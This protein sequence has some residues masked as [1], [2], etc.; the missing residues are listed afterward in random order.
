MDKQ[1]KE[2]IK[3]ALKGLGRVS[4]HSNRSYVAVWL[5]R[6]KTKDL[7]LCFFQGK[8][9]TRLCLPWSTVDISDKDIASI[10][11][12]FLDFKTR[13]SISKNISKLEKALKEKGLF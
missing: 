11:S 10:V 4:F 5:H 3:E 13:E 9:K 8:R 12:E 1:T 2:K 6:K 7:I